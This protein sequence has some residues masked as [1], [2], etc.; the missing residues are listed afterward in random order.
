LNQVPHM[1]LPWYMAP[2]KVLIWAIEVVGLL[3]RHG[4]LAVRLLANMVAGH[5]V[6]L[7]I[8]GLAVGVEGALSPSW[9]ITAVISVLGSVCFS[10]LELFVAFLQ[11]Y[12]F[13]FLSA[14]FIGSAVHQH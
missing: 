12:V 9:L 11:A 10:V 5:L 2:I 13:V 4:V 8:L 1:D 3:I 6:L 14:L 7:A